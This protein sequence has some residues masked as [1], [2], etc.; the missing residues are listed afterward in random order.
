MKRELVTDPATLAPGDQIEGVCRCTEETYRATVLYH[1][2]QVGWSQLPGWVFVE[3]V[4]SNIPTT[5]PDGSVA[6]RWKRIAVSDESIR[7]GRVYRIRRPPEGLT[8]VRR[9]EL[10]R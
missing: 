6:Q 4:P 10:V 1:A 2:D 5:R 3:P 9:K 7:A 8:V